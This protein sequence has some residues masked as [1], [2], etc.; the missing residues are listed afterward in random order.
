MSDVPVLRLLGLAL[1]DLALGRVAQGV[2][3]SQL[4]P[5]LKRGDGP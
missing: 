2:P 4:L 3:P 5:R 1:G